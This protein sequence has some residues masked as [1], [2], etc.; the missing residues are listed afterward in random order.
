M[1]LALKDV[2]IDNNNEP[3]VTLSN[4]YRASLSEVFMGRMSIPVYICEHFLHLHALRKI[5]RFVSRFTAAKSSSLFL[6][7]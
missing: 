3:I 7:R 2:L 5:K 1:L 6:K 4:F